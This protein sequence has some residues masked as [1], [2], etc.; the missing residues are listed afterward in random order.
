MGSALSQEPRPQQ[1]RARVLA[2]HGFKN[3]P[4]RTQ[5]L[6]GVTANVTEPGELLTF[7]VRGPGTQPPAGH[8]A[9]AALRSACL[10]Q[11]ATW[12]V[13]AQ[14]HNYTER[15]VHA[16]SLT[17]YPSPPGLF[18]DPHLPNPLLPQERP[19][20]R[21]GRG[22]SGHALI[23][24]VVF[25]PGTQN[26]SCWGHTEALTP[27]TAKYLRENGLQLPGNKKGF[28]PRLLNAHTAKPGRDLA[29]AKS[30]LQQL[31][32]TKSHSIKAKLVSVKRW[33]FGSNLPTPESSRF[34]VVFFFY[35]PT[36]SRFVRSANNS[37]Y[38]GQHQSRP[39]QISL[40]P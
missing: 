38:L 31:S 13:A 16:V 34:L 37:N 12:L 30:K 14:E 9:A 32:V 26:T 35:N 1:G 10:P 20:G 33:T 15:N 22:G 25:C 28:S 27:Y 21:R 2:P 23:H 18:P 36:T 19:R 3:Q 4:H 7:P 11:L 5:T 6:R 17:C 24:T 29:P 8:A 39:E 40:P